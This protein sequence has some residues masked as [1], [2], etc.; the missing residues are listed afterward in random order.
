[1]LPHLFE[2]F[3]KKQ[4]AENEETKGTGLGLAIV[5]EII[6]GHKGEIWVESEEHVGSIFY[7]ALPIKKVSTPLKKEAQ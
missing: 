7:I 3:Y 6:E 2:P 4:Y 5:K 1:M